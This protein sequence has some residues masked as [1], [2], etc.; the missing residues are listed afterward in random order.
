MVRRSSTPRFFGHQLSGAAGD[1][2]AALKEDILTGQIPPG[3]AIHEI[4]TAAR[5]RV[6]RSPVRDALTF[7]RAEG[8]IEAIPHRGYIASEVSL[9]DFT[10]VFHVR[11][12]LESEAAALAAEHAT[13]EQVEYLERLIN[14]G[15]EA[16]AAGA[17]GMYVRA[18]REFHLSL[19]E[20]GANLLLRQL[21]EQ[22][23]DRAERAITLG[24]GM[25]SSSEGV[26]EETARIVAAVKA[27]DAAGARQ[28]MVE[29]IVNMR[30][31]LLSLEG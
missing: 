30:R 7:L 18:N 8:F 22:L 24:V 19:A 12:T 31:R 21:I 28:A 16:E 3:G 5:F 13:A 25:R 11:K 15:Q 6:S 9:R 20:F 1:I 29:H 27:H 23:L 26:Y 17:L 4:E 10:E 2:H 14:R